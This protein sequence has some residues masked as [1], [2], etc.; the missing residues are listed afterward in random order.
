MN[1]NP[2]YKAIKLRVGNVATTF[3]WLGQYLPGK[4]N[5][6]YKVPAIYIEMPRDFNI[7]F[8]TGKIM[9]AKG[10]QVKIHVINN[11]PFKN[12]DPISQDTYIDEHEAMV[13]A[14]D[15]LVSGWNIADE[16]GKLLTQQFVNVGASV[17]NMN[18]LH[19][20]TVLTYVTEF[21]SRHLVGTV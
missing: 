9:V 16:N 7:D 3:R 8:F 11:A 5:T 4:D 1:T 19:I 12:H 17:N 14:V 15:N 13:A 18:G 20:Y 2:I 6:S 10:V 21:Y